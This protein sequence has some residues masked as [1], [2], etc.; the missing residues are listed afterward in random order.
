[1]AAKNL[2]VSAPKGHEENATWLKRHVQE[3]Q[4]TIVYLHEVQRVSEE[5]KMK[6]PQGA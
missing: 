2:E 4:D 3:A 6:K 5:Q 1:L